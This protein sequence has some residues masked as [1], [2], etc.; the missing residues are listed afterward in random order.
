M[1]V[2]PHTHVLGTAEQMEGQS[3]E[4]KTKNEL[5]LDPML[6]LLACVSVYCV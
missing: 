4:C 6:S 2:H 1:L 5:K 3:D